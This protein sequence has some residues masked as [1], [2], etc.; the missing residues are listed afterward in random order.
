[1]RV[2]RRSR[3]WIW[4]GRLVGGLVICAVA[5]YLFTSGLD[6]ADKVASVIGALA[7]LAAL[8][9][10]YLLPSPGGAKLDNESGYGHIDLRH[11]RGVQLSESGENVQHNFFVEPYDTQP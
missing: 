6:K 3:R 9:A 7:G 10:P 1:M 11:A 5:I 2:P 4:T 8:V